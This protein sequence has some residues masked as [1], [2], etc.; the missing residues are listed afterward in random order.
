LIDFSDPYG[1]RARNEDKL[2]QN[3]ADREARAARLD[4]RKVADFTELVEH[5]G[6]TVVA[7][8][9][10][11]SYAPWTAALREYSRVPP[12]IG[13]LPDD[14]HW[15]PTDL[16]NFAADIAQPGWTE[17]RSD[18]IEFAISFL[19]ADV[20]LFR[21]GYVKRHLIRRLQQSILSEDQISRVDTLLRRAITQGTGLEESRAFRKLAAHLYLLGYLPDLYEWLENQS[22]GVI[23]TLD[24]GGGDLIL[25]IMGNSEL[26]EQDLNRALS[27][28]FFGLSKWG[29]VYPQMSEVVRAGK[30]LKEPCQQI[31]YSAYLMLD[32]I[33][34]REAPKQT[35]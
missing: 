12:Y 3:E 15:L 2:R 9:R 8:K 19:E 24:R 21:S 11:C 26:S 34:K 30:L 29:I 28:S 5:I 6:Q 22:A 25:K 23:L 7:G 10:P 17:P 32:A 27:V 16:M 31:K 13:K 18:L 4:P 1:L 14:W 35:S 20:M 33:L